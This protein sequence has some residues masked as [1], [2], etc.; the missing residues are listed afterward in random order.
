MSDRRPS[1]DE[2]I[3][4]AATAPDRPT[5][6]RAL[7]RLARAASGPA[8]VR[9]FQ[10][11][12]GVGP[13]LALEFVARLPDGVPLDL[14]AVAVPHL[15]ADLSVALRLAAAGKLLSTVPDEPKAVAAVVAP[16]TAGLSPT[17]EL[18]RLT[19][20]QNRVA[21]CEALD[22][23]VAAAEARTVLQCPGCSAKLTRPKLI[24]HLWDRHRLTFAHGRAADPREEV[25][26]VITAAATS[27]DPAAIDHAFLLSR[28]Y[29][30]DTPPRMAFQALAARGNPDPT[31]TDRLLIRAADDRAG[32]CPVC[33]SAVPDP[34]PEL[35]PP[36]DVS[37]GRVAADGFVVA[38]GDEPLGRVVT[39]D[40]P[41]GP[42][43]PPPLDARMPP[44]LYAVLWAVPV[45]AFA[46]AST[47][48]FARVVPPV[49]VGVA[50]AALGWVVYSVV[51]SRRPPL[52]DRTDTAVNLAWSEFVPG[53]GRSPAA[54]R[55]LTRL[56]RASLKAGDP[57]A[58]SKAVFELVEH[59]AVLADKGG[60]Y[61]QLL[62]AARVLQV[63][64]GGRLGREPVAGLVEVFEP[65]ARGE[66]PPAYVEGVAETLLDAGVLNDGDM[67]RLGV[68][69][70]GVLFN[71]GLTAA[72]LVTVVRFCPGLR[73]LLNGAKPGDLGPLYAV[74]QGRVGRPWGHLG[75]SRTVFEVAHDTPVAG[76]RLLAA[77]PDLLFR[78]D[79]GEAAEAMIGPV[80]VLGRGVSVGGVTVADPDA[81]VEVVQ[82][83][84]GPRLIFGTHQLELTG[85]LP[86][87]TVELLRGW[88]RFR[89][90]KLLPLADQLAGRRSAGKVAALLAPLAVDC[91]LCGTRCV[92]RTGRLGT[93]WQA[94][95]GG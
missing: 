5:R 33:L 56:C 78:I 10:G 37:L 44:R 24:A 90:D 17:R 22:R 36:A 41:N 75:E 1:L 92:H 80:L 57:V 89:A 53:I 14:V 69:V 29:Y 38:V 19:Q 23:M 58:R 65:F 67:R 27:P 16:L 40:T 87:R 64:D 25:D 94:V 12:V 47:I 74:W 3:H 15:A 93:M 6:V 66:L 83:A 9:A 76:R 71:A 4:H 72:D 13:Q 35:P 54:V 73:Q 70:V 21:K 48:V 2:L 60:E 59:G 95:A 50:G 68:G 42:V 77:Y 51:L 45:L 28:H 46:A 61:A 86:A 81:R 84:N 85:R 8:T 43:P 49:L 32:V 55:Y 31:Q 34:L 26:A 82:A 18:E 62:A 52:P 7:V 79:L 39:L 11:L 30:P 88:L 20:L 63:W 91:H